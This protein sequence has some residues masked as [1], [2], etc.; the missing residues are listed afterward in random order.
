MTEEIRAEIER[1]GA[2]PFERFMQLALYGEQ[3]FY[4]RSDGGSAGRRGDFLTSPE[5]GPLF[6][7]VVARMLDA[8]WARLGRP[9]PFTVVDL[10]AG[11]GT[12]ARAVHAASPAC[13][14]AMHYVAVELSPA[15]R[16]RHPEHVASVAELAEVGTT[17]SLDGVVIA[18]EVLDNVPFQLAVFDGGWREAFVVLDGHG[19]LVE[20]LSAPF[21]PAPPVLPPTAAHGARAPLVGRAADLVDAARALLRSGTVVVVDYGV[22]RTA[23]LALRPWREW[24]RTYRSNERGGHYLANP[25]EQDITADMPVDQLPTHDALRTQAQWLARWG[26]DDLVAEG[27][28]VWAER[29]ARPDLEAMRMRSRISESEALLDP[30]GLGAFLALE[31]KND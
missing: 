30:A 13:R 17:G 5:V 24:L 21:D 31:W 19:E 10:G 23:E 27:K 7:A 8:E 22:A 14:D 9:D 18:N 28:Q 12:L 4:T 25:G 11:P 1:A 2:M 20:R 6:G 26:I 29:A 16:A 15:Q 3:G